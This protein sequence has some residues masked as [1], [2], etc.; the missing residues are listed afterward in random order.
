MNIIKK[1]SSEKGSQLQRTNINSIVT[2]G[3]TI[4]VTLSPKVKFYS[5][6]LERNFIISIRYKNSIVILGIQ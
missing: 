1:R 6:L 5:F 2:R 3:T 4:P